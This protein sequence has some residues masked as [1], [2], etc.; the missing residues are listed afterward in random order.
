MYRVNAGKSRLMFK[1]LQKYY[2]LNDAILMTKVP[3]R[4]ENM[5]F[6]DIMSDKVS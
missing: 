1:L 3:K 2:K 5:G 6:L 4:P